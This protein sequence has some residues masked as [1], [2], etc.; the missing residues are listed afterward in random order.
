MKLVNQYYVGAILCLIREVATPLRFWYS[1]GRMARQ[2]ASSIGGPP[3]EDKDAKR[4]GG[5]KPQPDANWGSSLQLHPSI[6]LGKLQS[7]QAI[8]QCV[9]NGCDMQPRSP[10]ET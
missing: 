3:L 6:R 10:I 7:E 1:P 2:K 4:C 5:I 9:V 8:R